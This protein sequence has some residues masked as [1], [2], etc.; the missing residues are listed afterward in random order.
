M[1]SGKLVVDGFEIGLTGHLDTV[2]ATFL[3]SSLYS[4]DRHRYEQL[5]LDCRLHRLRLLHL[6]DVNRLRED[7][8]T[9]TYPYEAERS[10]PTDVTRSCL[11]T[12]FDKRD[13]ASDLEGD[14]AKQQT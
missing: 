3:P 6:K 1:G 5:R 9:K 10:I 14:R 8:E 7:T 4:G 12:E 13:R 11:L 2:H